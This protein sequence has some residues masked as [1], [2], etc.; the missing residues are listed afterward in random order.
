MTTVQRFEQLEAWQR[1]RELAQEVYAITGKGSF[2]KDFILRDQIRRAAVSVVAN[3]AE[4]FERS[5][6][7]EFIQF[8]AVAKGS[9]GEL[10]SHVYIAHDQGYLSKAEFERLSDLAI[11]TA[12]L[13]GGLMNYLRGSSIKGTKFKKVVGL[14]VVSTRGDFA[15]R[16]T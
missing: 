12:Q 1:A 8:L 6:R 9:V 2:A 7:G 11:R 16:E 10:R 13:V 14:S 15:Q 5:G 4:G 3:I